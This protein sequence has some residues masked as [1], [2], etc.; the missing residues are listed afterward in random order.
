MKKLIYT[1]ITALSLLFASCNDYLETSSPSDLD[2]GTV[3]T[4]IYYTESAVKG[5]YD[6]IAD[7]QMYAQRLSINWTTNNDIEFVGADETSYNQNSNRGSSNYYA[8]AGNSTLV[9]TRIFDM[10]ER[11][12]LV[13]QGIEN[14][15]LIE[16]GT[17][18]EKKAMKALLAESK[19][20]RALGYF[21]LTRLWG[22]IPFKTEPTKNDLSNVYLPRTDRDEIL[23]YLIDELLIAEEDL[24]W[25]GES[26]GSVSYN[27]AERITR[28]FA[29]GLIAR[30]CLTRGGY[31][32]R[33]KPGFPTERGSEWEKY[34][35]IAHTKCREIIEAGLY[36]LKPNYTDIWQDV[37]ALTIDGVNGENLYEVAL[38]LSQSG[39]IG[40]SIGVRFYTNS[41]YGYGNNSN[42]VNTS[43]YYYYSFDREDP[44]RDATIATAMYG[45][46]SGDQKE[47]FQTNPLSYNFAKW[48]QRWMSKNTQ[49]LTQNLAANGKWGY[50]I[51]WIVMRYADVLLMY[52]E[53]ENELNGPTETAKGALREVRAR[54]F[55]GLPN[56]NEKVEGY[57]N[58]LSS[59][60]EFF[61]AIVNE[62]AWEFGGEGLRKFDLI[63]WNMLLSK[64][65]EQRDAFYNMIDGNP[66]RIMDKIYT[67]IPGYMYYKYKDDNENIDKANI[68]FYET[69]TD[70]DAMSDNE[71]K[72]LGYTKVR[73]IS[74]L[75]DADVIRVK[76]RVRLFSSGLLQEYNGVCDNRYIYPIHS[77][78]IGDYQ[79]IVT[80]SYGY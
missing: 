26:A 29:K 3:Y 56:A 39:E 40:Y 65:Q 72:N 23:S 75:S 43:A 31:A 8:T 42:V 11:S 30:M 18:S 62:R 17:E 76:D 53:T 49:W 50:G 48:D 58:A 54:A 33:D 74:N 59:K 70:L 6:R 36:Q 5:L 44:R 51:N 46:S 38:G 14:S 2:D 9:W 28:G 57:V 7:A 13:I 68:N 80:N 45:N 4:S 67:S 24:P 63:R 27:N 25:V 47:F 77:S 15:P 61:D 66:A 21:E 78:V 12:N 37:N 34:Y 35:G 20:I 60:E 10:L 79:G 71:L 73:W 19:V 55:A 1:S 22:D 16:G 41:K 32:L 64:I 69:R 52:A